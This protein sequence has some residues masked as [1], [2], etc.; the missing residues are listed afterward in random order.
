MNI[1]RLSPSPV[2]NHITPIKTLS[3]N[4][5]SLNAVLPNSKGNIFLNISFLLIWC[6]SQVLEQ[7]KKESVGYFLAFMNL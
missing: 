4:A 6:H 2:A 5:F 1:P 7:W 3:P